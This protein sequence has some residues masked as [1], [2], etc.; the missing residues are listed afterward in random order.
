MFIRIHNSETTHSEAAY[1]DCNRYRYRL[2]RTWDPDSPKVNF[3]MLNPSVA[4]EIRNDPTVARCEARARALGYGAF[5]VTN[6]FAWR[7]TDPHKMRKTAHPVG[8]ENDETLVSVADWADTVIAAWGVHGE[9]RDRGPQVAD[10]LND[11]GIQL[12]HLG[13]TRHGHPKHPLYLS[14]AE[15]PRQWAPATI[16]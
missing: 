10:I 12:H 5:C 4:D 13:L 16:D 6:I 7:D 3:I 9:H 15:Q 11:T 14:Y 8:P 2:K 1:S